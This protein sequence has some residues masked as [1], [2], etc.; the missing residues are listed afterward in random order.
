MLGRRTLWEKC[1]HSAG[2]ELASV[3]AN[4]ALSRS[5]SRAREMYVRTDAKSGASP[6]VSYVGG[7][8]FSEVPPNE[9]GYVAMYDGESETAGS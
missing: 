4:A 8:E 6:C 9:M 7:G 3:S 5:L 1:A 2:L